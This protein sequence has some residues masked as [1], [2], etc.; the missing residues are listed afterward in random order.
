MDVDECAG[1]GEEKTMI[2][3]EKGS[4]NPATKLVSFQRSETFEIRAEYSCQVTSTPS[5]RHSAAI[6]DPVGNTI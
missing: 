1:E 5:Q 4:A 3:F 6:F 2:I